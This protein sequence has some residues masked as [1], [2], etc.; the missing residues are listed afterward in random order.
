MGK[1]RVL[2]ADD[3]AFVRESI[4]QF[5]EK[6]PDIEVVGEA[7]DGEQM[8]ALANEL[9]PDVIIADVAMPNLN[10]I[11]ATRKIKAA[12]PS[13][14][15]LILTAYDFD[16]YVF[17][18]LEAGATSYLLKDISSQELIKGIYATYRGDSVLHPAIARKITQR[19]RGVNHATSST[20][21]SLTER[22]LDVIRLAALGKSNKEIADEL[23]LSIRT[24]ESHIGH[25]FNKLGV[26]SR[27]EAVI[28]ALRRGWVGLE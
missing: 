17:T 21:E 2:L 22:E 4:R 13:I 3:H 1:I 23:S 19:F 28:L 5:L 9:K 24:V 25:I 27:T 12:N 15:I 6:E 20:G 7:A 16:Q 18:L 8:V 14:T 26:N 10:G 11:E